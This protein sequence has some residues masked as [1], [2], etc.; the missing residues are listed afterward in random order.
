VDSTL[1]ITFG[2][3]KFGAP[4][5]EITETATEFLAFNSSLFTQ[6]V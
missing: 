3:M 5:D 6:Q 1:A 4:V 2:G